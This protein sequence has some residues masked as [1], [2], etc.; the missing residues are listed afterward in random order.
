MGDRGD[1]RRGISPSH[2]R[3]RHTGDSPSPL[4][5]T[6]CFFAFA[7]VLSFVLALR[8]L[9]SAVSSSSSSAAVPTLE[10]RSPVRGRRP[11]RRISRNRRLPPLESRYFCTF[12]PQTAAP[13]ARPKRIQWLRAAAPTQVRLVYWDC[14]S[15]RTVASQAYSSYYSSKGIRFL[16]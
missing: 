1:W 2:Q 10:Q 15:R 14:V 13:A 7:I 12:L 4:C 5:T 9:P 3:Q 11:P 6:A 8:C 16:G